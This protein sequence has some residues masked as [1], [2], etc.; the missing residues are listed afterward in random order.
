MNSHFVGETI[1]KLDTVDSTNNF[2]AKKLLQGDLA[3]GTVIMASFQSEGK[4]QRGSN[5]ESKKGL[6]LL[7]SIVLYPSFLK[8]DEQFHLSKAV[9]VAAAMVLENLGIG[10]VSIKWPND[11]L[12]DEQKIGG[13]LIENTLHSGR[14]DSSVVGIGLN[15]NEQDFSEL[16]ATSILL[17]TGRYHSVDEVGGSLFKTFNALY[18]Q[19]KSGNFQRIDEH[20]N[21][22]LFGVNEAKSYEIKGELKNCTVDRVSDSGELFL[23]DRQGIIGPLG[24]REVKWIPG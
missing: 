8:A 7:C 24:V 23:R 19:L 10:K 20:Y 15:V 4:G 16:R 18:S 2:T 14:L 21:R 1:I 9:S 12:S 6:N 22:L 13:I 3:E 5:W 17:E 11:I